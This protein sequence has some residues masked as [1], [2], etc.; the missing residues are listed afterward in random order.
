MAVN[1]LKSERSMG[2]RDESPDQGECSRC[3][4]SPKWIFD[5]EARSGSTVM[6]CELCGF[7]V[8][9]NRGGMI[10]GAGMMLPREN[11]LGSWGT[12]SVCSSHISHIGGTT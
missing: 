11:V 1:W 8:F 4:G 12:F 10:P 9:L 2:D 6:Q 5:I 3:G 7:V